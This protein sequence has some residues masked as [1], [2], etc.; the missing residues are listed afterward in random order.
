MDRILQEGASPFV[1]LTRKKLKE[2]QIRR[3]SP[4]TNSNTETREGSS[5]IYEKILRG[6][7]GVIHPITR[8]H[9]VKSTRGE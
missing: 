9:V 8:G 4:S 2:N 7:R 3:S 1:W 6:K 5:G